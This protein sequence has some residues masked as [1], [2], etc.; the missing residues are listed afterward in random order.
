MRLRRSL[1]CGFATILCSVS[2]V[3]A[4]HAAKR[5]T[6][7]G[8]LKRLASEGKLTPEDATAKRAIY[9]DAKAI[10]KKLTGARKTE[11]GGVI[12]DLDG[13]AERGSFSQPSR[14]PKQAP[15]A[16]SRS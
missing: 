10:E 16:C 15:F 1:C 8:E 3:P 7:A 14:L 2:I 5:L 4:A 13:M 12:R 9:D 11:L 6:V